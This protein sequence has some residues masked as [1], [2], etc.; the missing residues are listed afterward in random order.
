MAALLLQELE[1]SEISKLPK[2]VQNKLEKVFSDQQYEI[3]SLKA[4]QEQFRVDSEQH[5]FEKVKQLAQCQEKCLSTT[6]EHLKLKEEFA[7]Q[8][9]DVKSLREKNREYESSQERLSSEQTLLSKAKEELEAEKRELL[10]TLEKRSL[11]VEH[12]NDDFRQLNDKLAEVNTSKMA[13]QMKLDEL[14][15]AEVNIKYKEKRM[16]Q[17]KV[18]LNGQTSWLNGE[19]KAKSEELLSLS[20]QKGNDI[21]ELKCN[22]EN[23]EDEAFE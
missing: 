4:Q 22:L 15:S 17:E 9:E 8:V 13:L 7:K 11:Q 18:L 16:E 10:R 20:R 5:F 2:T 6:Q 23:K 19:L 21:L 14:E 3:D 1:P 12:L